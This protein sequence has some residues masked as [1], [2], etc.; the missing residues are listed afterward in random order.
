M[1]AQSGCPGSSREL[2]SGVPPATRVVGRLTGQAFV[3]PTWR[4]RPSASDAHSWLR[5]FASGLGVWTGLLAGTIIPGLGPFFS[6]AGA[7]TSSVADRDEGILLHYQGSGGNVQLCLLRAQ[8]RPGQDAQN[9]PGPG[10]V[11]GGR[12][13]AAGKISCEA[14]TAPGA[15][16]AV[17]AGC[18]TWHTRVRGQVGVG[19]GLWKA[20]Q[21]PVSKAHGGLAAS[22]H[23]RRLRARLGARGARARVCLVAGQVCGVLVGE[24]PCHD[25]GFGGVYRRGMRCRPDSPPAD[26]DFLPLPPPPPSIRAFSPQR[27]LR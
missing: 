19:H 26:R 18:R 5:R 27:G 14:G 23:R 4:S 6:N 9:R 3:K 21:N 16:L 7:R 13:A 1:I 25:W 10:W 22:G 2:A 20:A 8:E 15:V 11:L 24:E 12:Q 17:R